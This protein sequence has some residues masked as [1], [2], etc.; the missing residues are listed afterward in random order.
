MTERFTPQ[1]RIRFTIKAF[2]QWEIDCTD[3]NKKRLTDFFSQKC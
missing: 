1:D 3:F 2:R